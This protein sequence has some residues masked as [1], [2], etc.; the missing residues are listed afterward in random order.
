M[1]AVGPRS[2]YAFSAFAKPGGRL[3]GQTLTVSTR[4]ILLFRLECNSQELESTLDAMKIPEAFSQSQR[5]SEVVEGPAI[6]RHIHRY[7]S[8]PFRTDGL[9]GALYLSSEPDYPPHLKLVTVFHH[10]RSFQYPPS[11]HFFTTVALVPVVLR[12]SFFYKPRRP[13]FP[14]RPSRLTA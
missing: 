6:R 3:L 13:N 12:F 8:S 11:P 10:H 1:Q 5:L 7:V 2:Q 9:S 14:N 4:I